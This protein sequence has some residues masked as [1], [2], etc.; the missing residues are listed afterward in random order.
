MAIIQWGMHYPHQQKISKYSLTAS[1]GGFEYR[2]A[3]VRYNS[4]IIPSTKVSAS[5]SIP[6]ETRS[7]R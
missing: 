6:Y 4:D 3:V 2:T 1:S 5:V 7:L